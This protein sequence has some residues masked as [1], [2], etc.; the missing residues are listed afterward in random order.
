M[1]GWGTG[2]LGMHSPSPAP[3]DPTPSGSVQGPLALGP[4][5]AVRLTLPATLAS[6]PWRAAW[7][8]FSAKKDR[9]VNV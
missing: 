5:K 9:T 2:A 3:V 1:S 4:A 6:F 8:K 7:L